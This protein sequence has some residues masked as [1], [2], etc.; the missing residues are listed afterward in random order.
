MEGVSIERVK[1]LNF[2]QQALFRVRRDLVSVCYIMLYCFVLY[3]YVFSFV[4]LYVS[5]CTCALVRVCSCVHVSCWHF[6][7]ICKRT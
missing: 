4:F 2:Q 7:R 3:I 6:L 1:N 5:V